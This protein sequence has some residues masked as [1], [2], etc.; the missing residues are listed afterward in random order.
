MKAYGVFFCSLTTKA[1]KILATIGYSTQQF[2][3]CYKKFTSNQGSPATVL[4]DHGTQLL[5][6]ARK[7]MDPEA[8]DIDWPQVVGMTGRSGTRWI[9][10]EK[11]CPWRN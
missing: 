3:V 6:A 2:L 8:R 9:F 4:S 7:L 10:S 5:S 1:V 11:G